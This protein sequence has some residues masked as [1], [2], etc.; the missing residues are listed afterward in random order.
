MRRG[1]IALVAATL[2]LMA[3]GAVAQTAQPALS[4]GVPQMPFV[5]LDDARLFSDSA[6][7]KALNKRL[8]AE[9]TGL[10]AENREIE[11]RLA[12]Q[13][14]DLTARRPDLPAAE[15]RTLADRFNAEVESWRSTQKAKEQAI[16]QRHEAAR[17]RFRDVANQVLAQLMVERGALAII[18]EEA[19]VLG[20]REIDITADAVARLDA[21][22][23][24]GSNLPEPEPAGPDAPVPPA[25][26]G[27]QRPAP[28][29][30]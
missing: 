14:R 17:L 6:W 29:T 16:Y 5:T 15:F 23:G 9:Q 2:A 13:E 4:Q 10:A 19:I 7:G 28:A 25:P 27:A 26:A 24:D 22:V 20:F 18:A 11:A 30:P 21:L 3:G 1:R 8:E 12:D